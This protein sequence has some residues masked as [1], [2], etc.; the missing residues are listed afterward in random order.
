MKFENF[1]NK[2]N[3]VLTLVE[4]L[5]PHKIGYSQLTYQRKTDFKRAS[6]DYLRKVFEVQPSYQL[7]YS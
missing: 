4:P 3:E 7:N 2:V 1:V 5:H 6:H